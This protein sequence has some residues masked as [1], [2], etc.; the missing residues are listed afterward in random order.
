MHRLAQSYTSALALYISRYNTEYEADLLM[1]VVNVLEFFFV[2]IV[3]T[4]TIVII[5]RYLSSVLY[6]G[7][8]RMFYGCGSGNFARQ[9]TV[10]LSDF[11][12]TEIHEKR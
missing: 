4:C 11:L 7:C 9:K 8:A 1:F 12:A 10:I 5:F 2:F 3:V 6:R